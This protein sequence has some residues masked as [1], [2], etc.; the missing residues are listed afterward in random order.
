MASG[1]N[2]AEIG[3]IIAQKWNFPEVISHSIR[4][5]HEPEAAPEDVKN[6]VGVV[7]FANMLVHYSENDIEY[8]QFDPEILKEFRVENEEQLKK[9]AERL[10]K[11]FEKEN[12]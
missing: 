12:S 1:S 6:L 4:Y 3:S 9:I 8:Y 10:E 2:H 5:H 11:A 7:Y